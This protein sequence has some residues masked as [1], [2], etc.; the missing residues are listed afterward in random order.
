M[1]LP[2]PVADSRCVRLAWFPVVPLLVACA[3]GAAL[4]PQTL[5]HR[6]PG[7]PAFQGSTSVYAV[8]LAAGPVRQVLRLH[9]QWEFPV[10]TRDGRALLLERPGLT[11]T[12]VWRVAL[13]G[14]SKRLVGAIRVFRAPAPFLEEE[15]RGAA[16]WEIVLHAP[17]FTRQMPF[18]LGVASAAP[19][20]TRVAAVRMHLLELVTRTSRRLLARDAGSFTA[21]VWTLDGR[22]LVYVTSDSRVVVLD[23]ATG[24]KRTLARGRY[25]E[26]TLS[27][28]G[29]TIYM[30][31]LN[32]AVSI[33]K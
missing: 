17:R 8:P 11:K 23:V 9:G 31:G 30:L 24:A 28:D 3:A 26:P 4:V 27:A 20:G 16:G 33:P 22:A 29:T 10:A 6:H 14:S 2:R 32:E 21:P 13:D 1:L 7:V 12:G 18:P 25:F 5:R 19:G 15:V